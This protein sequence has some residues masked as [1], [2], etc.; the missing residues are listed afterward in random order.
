[1]A[2]GDINEG[3]LVKIL[4]GPQCGTI[5]YVDAMGIHTVETDDDKYEYIIKTRGYRVITDKRPGGEWVMEDKLEKVKYNES[6]I[7]QLL[8]ARNDFLEWYASE[9][10]DELDDENEE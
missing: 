7:V 6:S 5:G 8:K 9:L 3:N 10:E 1:M 4:D 2:L